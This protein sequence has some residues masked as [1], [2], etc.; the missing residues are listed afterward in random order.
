MTV[1]RLPKLMI[2]M[3]KNADVLKLTDENGEPH[4]VNCDFG[5]A[6]ATETRRAHK[7]T[8]ETIKNDLRRDEDEPPLTV[9]DAGRALQKLFTRGIS[10]MV[11]LFGDEREKLTGIFQDNFPAWRFGRSPAVITMSADLS[12]FLPLEFLPVFKLDSWPRIIDDLETLEE[13]ARRFP[14]FSAIIKREFYNMKVPQDT[15]LR[16][17]PKLPLKCFFEQSL[18]GAAVEVEFFRGNQAID[19]DGP[20]PDSKLQ[21]FPDLLAQYL[22]FAE[23]SFKGGLRS[24]ADQIQ[25]FVCHCVINEGI[26]SNS[27]L[28]LSENDAVT[29]ADLQAALTPPSKLRNREPGPLIF[30][31]ACGSASMDPMVVASF[32]R[33]FLRDNHN[34]GFI[35]TETNVPDKFAAEF[36]RCFYDDLLNGVRLGEAIYNAKWKMLCNANNPLGI[37]YTFYADPDMAVNKEKSK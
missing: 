11:N 12:R 19:L 7:D 35:G 28:I 16:G 9:Q 6:I 10:T 8:L 37:L 1:R 32:P 23:Q 18:P 34:R 27:S 2:E 14:G 36:S 30:L 15:V 33:F 5:D 17:D 24:Q 29:I 20:W 31:N 4:Y 21:G 22:Q 25:H 26:P 13:A 3:V